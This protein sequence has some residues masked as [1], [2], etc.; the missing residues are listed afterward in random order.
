MNVYKVF[1]IFCMA[2]TDADTDTKR[3][4]K[5]TVYFDAFV[6]LGYF[7][8]SRGFFLTKEANQDPE[9]WTL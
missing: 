8:E 1:M 7:G 6:L 3:R 4:T 5:Q 2:D 9:E